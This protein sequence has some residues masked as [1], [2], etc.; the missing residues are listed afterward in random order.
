MRRILNDRLIQALAISLL[1]TTFLVVCGT[2]TTASGL[3]S[4]HI[5]LCK[6]WNIGLLIDCSSFVVFAVALLMNGNHV[7]FPIVGF[8]CYAISAILCP[9]PLFLHLSHVKVSMPM[10][11]M[12]KICELWIL[13]IVHFML[14]YVFP[15]I[16]LLSYDK[17]FR[18]REI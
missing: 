16:L 1:C 13:S 8:V 2:L 3:I 10:L 11:A 5:R 4:P 15:K 12:V 17:Y 14:Q 9:N 18:R 7:G 6:V